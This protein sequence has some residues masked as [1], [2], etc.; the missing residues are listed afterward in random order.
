MTTTPSPR[1]TDRTP[2]TRRPRRA[3]RAQRARRLAG[4][5]AIAVATAA[6]TA[7]IT[8]PTSAAATAGTALTH[9]TR[10]DCVVDHD[11]QAG[12]IVAGTTDGN[13]RKATGEYTPGAGSYP[14]VW[15]IGSVAAPDG[16]T[17]TGLV[18]NQWNL[19]V[20]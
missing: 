2:H 18:L 9:G 15:F 12:P 11:V 3:Q 1:I 8:A 16:N 6:L 7:G 19:P 4:T 17:Y 20:P 10:V 14:G 5:A 13:C